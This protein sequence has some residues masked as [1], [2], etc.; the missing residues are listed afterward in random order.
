[1]FLE[2]LD[3]DKDLAIIAFLILVIYNMSFIGSCSPI[4]CRFSVAIFGI[5][6]IALSIAA[7]F[8]ICIK[9]EYKQ[10]EGHEAM[11]I[12]LL[13]IG[14]DD[15]FIICNALDQSSLK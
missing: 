8:G 12:L 2:Q 4:H 1:M 3:S 7:G 13:G 5:I 15:M 14:I 9:L 11:P 10:N 6:C